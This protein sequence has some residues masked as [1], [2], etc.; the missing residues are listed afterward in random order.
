MYP[1]VSTSN[2]NWSIFFKFSSLINTKSL[3]EDSNMTKLQL[4]FALTSTWMNDL[5]TSMR[6]LDLKAKLKQTKSS[7]STTLLP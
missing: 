4:H 2:K 3:I 6:N 1:Y 7:Q 5:C